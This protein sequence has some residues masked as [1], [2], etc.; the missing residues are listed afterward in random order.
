MSEHLS[1]LVSGDTKIT[2]VFVVLG[3]GSWLGAR[4]LTD[5]QLVQFAV[6]FGVGVVVSVWRDLG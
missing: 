6:L 1:G 5:S 3:V 4:D 2:A